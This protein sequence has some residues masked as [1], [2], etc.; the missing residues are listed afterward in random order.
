MANCTFDPPVSTPISRRQRSARVA[1][2]L[3]FA[4]GER[5]RG[6]DGDGIAGVDAHRIEVFDRA[7]DD[8]V[9]RQ[10]AHHFQLVFFPAEHALFDQDFMHGRKV[11]AALQNLFQFF[12]VVGDAAAGA[13]HR[14]A[15]PQDD[16]ISV[17]GGE[18]DA[19]LRPS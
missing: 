18:L 10:V 4:V 5:L 14:K 16:R 9:V 17:L 1:H 3:I 11:E 12:A 6:R 8:G 7:D 19:R 13:A 15:G 2:H